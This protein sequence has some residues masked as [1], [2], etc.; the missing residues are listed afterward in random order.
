MNQVLFQPDRLAV[1]VPW[2]TLNRDGPIVFARPG[3]GN[4]L[5]DHRDHA[6]WLGEKPELDLDGLGGGEGSDP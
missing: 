4:P 1:V 6:L 2:P 3:T 5:A